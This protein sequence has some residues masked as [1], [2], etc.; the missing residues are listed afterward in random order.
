M[1]ADQVFGKIEKVL[2]KK[3]IIAGPS[4]YHTI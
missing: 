2:R 3:K 4:Q 1:A